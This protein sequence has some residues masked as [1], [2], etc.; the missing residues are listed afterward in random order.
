MRETGDSTWSDLATSLGHLTQPR[1]RKR[2]FIG[3]WCIHSLTNFQ[4]S[5]C[6]C[7]N[8]KILLGINVLKI[9]ISKAGPIKLDGN[10]VIYFQ[11]QRKSWNST[12]K[13]NT[14]ISC[15]LTDESHVA[16]TRAKIRDNLSPIQNRYR[17]STFYMYLFWGL[18]KKSRNLRN[19]WQLADDADDGSNSWDCVIIFLARKSWNA[20]NRAIIFSKINILFVVHT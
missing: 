2:I 6:I 17:F 19:S 12:K 13:C 8:N 5:D 20:S 15:T 10:S 16:C 7:S 9:T 14:M 11:M 4:R 18:H 1:L 3:R